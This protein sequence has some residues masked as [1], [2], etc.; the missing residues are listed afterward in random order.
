MAESILKIKIED[1]GSSPGTPRSPAPPD[2]AAPLPTPPA[3]PAPAPTAA[4]APSP[5]FPAPAPLVTPVAAPL[6]APTAVPAGPATSTV[7][8]LERPTPV[9]IVGP[10][11][12]PV[13]VT[14]HPEA[15]GA[16]GRGDSPRPR[17]P[18]GVRAVGAV[19]NVAGTVG[20]TVANAATG[21]GM[22]AMA[23]ATVG[24]SQ[25]IGKLGAVGATAG[26]GLMAVGAAAKL[27][28][29]TTLALVNRGRELAGFDPGLAQANAAREVRKIQDDM[30]EA[31]E[32]SASLSKLT[33]LVSDFESSF[34]EAVLPIKQFTIDFLKEFLTWFKEVVIDMLRTIKD[35]RLVSDSFKAWAQ[36]VID[37]LEG[38]NKGDGNID[39]LL[40]AA[41]AALPTKP[42]PDPA[43]EARD[44]KLGLPI[45]GDFQ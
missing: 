25:A 39:D 14:N 40:R 27:V 16:G 20:H 36:R 43:A 6:V 29:E 19:R 35:W 4:P 31:K 2:G 21:Q 42:N 17:I 23:H 1:D 26:A 28:Q 33:D 15:G 30:R 34:R 9:L 18:R 8:A 24:A 10:K 32:T 41:A 44:R 38:K 7:P 3:P 37:A 45:L 22:A 11:P 5:A 12:I 13:S